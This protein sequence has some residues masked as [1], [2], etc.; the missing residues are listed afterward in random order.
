MKKTAIVLAAVLAA[1][2]AGTAVV[3][4]SYL[5]EPLHA[6]KLV[7]SFMETEEM[8]LD[9]NMDLQAGSDTYA[10]SGDVYRTQLS[11]HDV[12]TVSAG[13]ADVYYSDGKLFLAS[14]TVWNTGSV[15]LNNVNDL[16]AAAGIAR[17]AVTAYDQETGTFTISVNAEQA[18][19][20]L[21]V[22]KIEVPEAA[23]TP[24]EAK[25]TVNETELSVSAKTDKGMITFT[26]V[27]TDAEHPG[28]P[29]AVQEAVL[30]GKEG[31]DLFSEENI[32]LFKSV[33]KF[34]CRET[35]SADVT[36]K[37]DVS[38]L[39]L[40]NTM[41]YFRKVTD[42]TAVSSL[43][44]GSLSVYMADG[45]ICSAD[46]ILLKDG[47]QSLSDSLKLAETAPALILSGDLVCEQSEDAYVYS[48]TL[49]DETMES[50][51]KA[52]VP[53]IASVNMTLQDGLFSMSI[54]DDSI[55]S[56]EIEIKGS[57]S[58]FSS[59]IPAGITAEIVMTENEFTIPSAVIEALK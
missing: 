52:A 43:Q 38:I 23:G 32:R 56:A 35:I 21:S 49:D 2:A 31:K 16:A 24:E 8:S 6:V 47:E 55:A 10:L 9:V 30:S 34:V 59:E 20:V 42:G 46:G 19:K 15:S 4:N 51:L 41:Q 26:A 12:F 44:E 36:I 50:I 33:L 37:G 29:S 25:I 14:G 40:S 22:L 28:I 13:Q 1:G 27:M 17:Y 39:S 48:L 58:F 7:R 3:Y 57:V 45:K 11:G 53:Q 54:K 5:K 18:E